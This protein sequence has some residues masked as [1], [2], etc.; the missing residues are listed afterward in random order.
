MPKI[1]IKEKD[2]TTNSALNDTTNGIFLIDANAG[3][4]VPTL[5]SE[6][7]A[8]AESS[9]SSSSEEFS[10]FVNQEFIEKALS[11]GGIV[12]VC[13]TYKHAK[14]YISDRNAFDIKFLLVDEV[15]GA[16]QSDL[17][18]AMEIAEARKD[19]AIILT[20][21]SHQVQDSTFEILNEDLDYL[22]SDKFYNDE[23]KR[24]KGKYVIAYYGNLVPAFT[25]GQAYILA[26]LTSIMKGNAE[27]LAIA[28]ATR[29]YIPDVTD[30]ELIK[31][32]ELD[33]MQPDTYATDKNGVAVNPICIVNPWGVRIW[34]ARTCLPNTSVE[35]KNVSQLVA[36]SFANIRVLICDIKKAL[37][38]ASK[39]YMFEQNNDVLYINFTASVN[40]LLEQMV[41]SYGIAGYRWFR[42][43][44]GVNS[45]IKAKLQIIPVDPV[46][47]FDITL[48]LADSL[49]VAE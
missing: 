44:S 31:E 12:Y 28:G 8:E 23:Q 2:L 45:K 19:C 34:G 9:T 16:T 24:K 43:E 46:D 6:I 4:T 27:W 29:G 33:K 40:S 38:V 3:V 36:S 14:D 7:L 15:E 42:E 39:K 32:S 30:A 21:V 5:A 13:D 22:A 25:A 11:L 18:E 20:T 35:D 41:Q 37:Y 10:G 47:S 26:Y 48:E 49:E 17:E 1:R